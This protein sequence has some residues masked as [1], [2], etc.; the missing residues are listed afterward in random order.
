MNA[1]VSRAVIAIG[2]AAS[3][4]GGLAGSPDR[5]PTSTGACN[6]PGAEAGS[7]PFCVLLFSR[8]AAY[9]LARPTAI[10]ALM[11]LQI[12]GGYQAVATEDPSQ[13]DAD[14]LA[15][16][17]V[18]VFLM[19]TGDVLDDAQQAAFEAWIERGGQLPR[20]SFPRRT[21]STT[22][23]STDSSSVPISCSTRTFNR[24]PV[25]IEDAS[26]PAVAGLPSPWS[27]RD[28]SYDFRTNPRPNVTVLATL[29][30]SSYVGGT[31]GTDRPIV[32]A[33][34]TAG[35]RLLHGHGPHQGSYAEPAF[36]QH[37]LA[38]LRWP[39]TLSVP[40]TNR[41]PLRGSQRTVRQPAFLTA[42]PHAE[43]MRLQTRASLPAMPAAQL[44]GGYGHP[45][46]CPST[47]SYP[48]ASRST[49]CLWTSSTNHAW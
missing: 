37:L 48:R 47:M 29:D 10:A 20:R 8:T 33:H 31:M 40:R 42:T 5:Q 18:V 12:A 7:D 41:R 46:G 27:R 28:E 32:W 1:G 44:A 15:R 39:R 14:N 25:H 16:F 17:A 45:S 6:S 21:P 11:D 38:A 24:R 43:V 49:E 2:L 9:R 22:G 30:E 13:L 4:C 35:A 19:T 23:H 3:G 34:A 36:R 26:H